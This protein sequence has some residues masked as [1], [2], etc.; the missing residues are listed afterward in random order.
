MFIYRG[1]VRGIES[2]LSTAR[3]ESS[4]TFDVRG[5][6]IAFFRQD[7][8]LIMCW[9]KRIRPVLNETRR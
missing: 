2:V 3:V 4:H 8:I 7:V 5:D 1:R 6:R 9:G